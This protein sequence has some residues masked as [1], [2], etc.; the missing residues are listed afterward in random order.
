MIDPEN[1]FTRDILELI[2]ARIP[3][4]EYRALHRLQQVARPWR[5]VFGPRL[6]ALPN[7]LARRIDALKSST[8]VH[9]YREQAA[10]LLKGIRCRDLVEVLS[11]TRPPTGVCEAF[12]LLSVLVSSATVPRQ[13]D[14]TPEWSAVKQSLCKTY[15]HH[16]D[17]AP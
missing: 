17:R 2:G 13:G 3:A 7:G 11:L 1:V 10:A 6:L 15:T 8:S 4:W 5:D 16:P 14:W 12:H 9:S